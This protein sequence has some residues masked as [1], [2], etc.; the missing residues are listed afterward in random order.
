MNYFNQILAGYFYTQDELDK[1]LKDYGYKKQNE[2]FFDKIKCIFKKEKIIN[3]KGIANS[4]KI[5][6]INNNDNIL[7]KKVVEQ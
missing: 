7:I 1:I 5:Y 3:Y 6:Y 2:N 4:L